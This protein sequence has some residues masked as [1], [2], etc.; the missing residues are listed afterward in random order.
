[1]TVAV[2]NLTFSLDVTLAKTTNPTILQDIRE[3]WRVDKKEKITKKVLKNVSF[4]IQEKMMV[5]LLGPPG[6]FFL[7]FVLFLFFVF[8]FL[9]FGFWFL[10]FGFWF[11]FFVF[12][13]LF[14]VF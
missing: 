13:F 4:V 7:F 11:L 3:R 12:C 1:M 6:L 2:H 10:V 9:V 5:L 8:W 14:F